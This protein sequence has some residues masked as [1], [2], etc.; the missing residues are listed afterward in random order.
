MSTANPAVRTAAYIDIENLCGTASPT[1]YD[2]ELVR[3]FCS[4]HINP[5]HTM[6]IGACSHHAA[7]RASFAWP[8]A[9]WLWRSGRDGADNALLDEIRDTSVKGRFDHIVIG[10]GDSIFADA[11]NDLVAAG[12][13]VTVISRSRSL[14]SRLAHSSVD[15]VMYDDLPEAPVAAA[16]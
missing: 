4:E 12:V 9:R 6:V 15:L 2:C 1:T 5:Q 11:V 16:A 7:P 13:R 3:E 10:S 8:T 14:S